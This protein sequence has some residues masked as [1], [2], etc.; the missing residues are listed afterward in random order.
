MMGQLGQRWVRLLF[1]WGGVGDGLSVVGALL[2]GAQLALLDGTDSILSYGT[3]S[4]A[5]QI[6]FQSNQIVA[7]PDESQPQRTLSPY[8]VSFW[9]IPTVIFFQIP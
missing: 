6:I 8:I 9:L 7:I 2:Y 4:I 3:N 1:D 5:C